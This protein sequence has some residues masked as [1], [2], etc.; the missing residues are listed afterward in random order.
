MCAMIHSAKLLTAHASEEG[1]ADQRP[2]AIFD[3]EEQLYHP[4]SSGLIMIRIHET[5]AE[6]CRFSS[7]PTTRRYL[8]YW[9]G[10]RY[11]VN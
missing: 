4:E 10:T 9:E 1:P 8:R 3:G 6:T 5:R 2:S 11:F 7:W